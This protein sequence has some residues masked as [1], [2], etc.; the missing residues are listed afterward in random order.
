MR[1][2]L[3]IV[4]LAGLALPVWNSAVCAEDTPAKIKVLII[5][6]DD[7]DVHHWK[8]T[9]AAVRKLL[10]DS[11]KFD[12]QVSEDLKPLESADALNACDVLVLN[13]YNRKAPLSDAGKQNLLD[14]VRSGKGLYVQHLASASFPKWDEFGKLCGRHWVM[15]K[16][17]HG[18]RG[19]FPATIADKNHPI[20]AGLGGFQADDELYAKLEGSEPVQ[21]LVEAYSAWS[22]KTEPLVFVQEFGKG[23][24][25]HNT[26]GHDPKAIAAPEVTTIIAR[27]VEWAATGKVAK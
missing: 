25:V 12:V 20:T 17:G 18:P 21:V 4:A 14:F 7:V 10:L 15:G 23:R 27:G 16:S 19:V 8:E 22:K 11:G 24:V 2:F 6:G 3:S 5:T 13:R 26:L 9:T 1:R